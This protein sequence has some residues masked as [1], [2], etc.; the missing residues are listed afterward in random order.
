MPEFNNYKLGF[1]LNLNTLVL[2]EETS[3]LNAHSA[4]PFL[5]ELYAYLIY[6][7]VPCFVKFVSL[8]SEHKHLA[9]R[10]QKLIQTTKTKK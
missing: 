3:L 4:T 6:K 9:K 2:T 10:F 1:K 5:K 7:N 8:F